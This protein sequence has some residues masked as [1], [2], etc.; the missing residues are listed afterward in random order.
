MS[1]TFD[2]TRIPPSDRA[3]VIRD[4]IWGRV[5]RVDIR[6]HP[7]Q[8]LISAVGTISDVGA[9]NI[10]S[11][12]SN[13]TV[14]RR[15]PSLVRDDLEPSLFL[16]LQVSGSSMVVQGG[17]EAVLR[18]GDLAVYD[19]T[20]PY[21]LV[22]ESGI[23]QHYFRI[24]RRELALPPAVLSKVTAVRLGRDHPVADL[25]STY[26]TRLAET[27][28]GMDPQQTEAVER[29]SVELLR[30]ALATRLGESR[31]A[32]ESLES[33][34]QYRITEYMRAHL[35]EHDLTAARIARAHHISVRYLYT[36]LARSGITLGDWLRANRL[37]QCRKE[38]ARPGN[39]SVTI[40]AVAHR[41]GFTS[42]SHFSRVFKEAYGVSPREWRQSTDRRA[43]GPG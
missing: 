7:R 12:R 16:G 27:R 3:E 39:R 8:E 30:A 38:L 11:V 15:T 2:T 42:A 32:Q 6:H 19:T 10:C 25:A 13:A 1:I 5:V 18:P 35:A 23:H 31:L 36:I 37:E 34:L 41:W 9:L 21:T 29:P 17:R 43:L 28:P 14:V 26:F 4:V 22:N 40:A 33:T 24:P 20:E